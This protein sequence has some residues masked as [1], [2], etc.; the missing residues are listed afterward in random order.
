MTIH[1]CQVVATPATA[2]QGNIIPR[3]TVDTVDTVDRDPWPLGT[4]T[5]S[6]GAAVCSRQP[7][8][9]H[10]AQHGSS[11]TATRGPG[12]SMAHVK[13][14]FCEENYEAELETRRRECRIV[15]EKV[16]SEGS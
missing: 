10:I 12:S 13:N 6:H 3:Y 1:P 15:L 8:R 9:Q 7:A 2:G 16:P 4:V 11:D 5:G 14:L